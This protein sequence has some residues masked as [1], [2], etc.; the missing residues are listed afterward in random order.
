LQAADGWDAVVKLH[1]KKREGIPIIREAATSHE[2]A[3]VT[4]PKSRPSTQLSTWDNLI[5]YFRHQYQII[6]DRLEQHPYSLGLTPHVYESAA[7]NE[8]KKQGWFS[9]NH[10]P[11][12]ANKSNSATPRIITMLNTRQRL[13][14]ITFND[15]YFTP[16]FQY[17]ATILDNVTWFNSNESNKQQDLFLDRIIASTPRLLL[18]ANA[19]LILTY[20]L[21]G[22]VADFFLGPI[23]HYNTT[24]ESA[25]AP[26]EEANGEGGGTTDNDGGR[27]PR[28]ETRGRRGRERL[29][30]YMLFKVLLISTVVTP[31]VC[32]L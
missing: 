15:R 19:F 11:P 2:A 25:T 13:Q 28:N 22:A 23:Q 16:F 5:N 18:L 27:R 30:G 7:R 3:P 32:E 6:S 12:L 4:P 14:S 9:W 29:L 31:D 8:A 21:H 17:I 10:N 1:H 24:R 20:L 26:A